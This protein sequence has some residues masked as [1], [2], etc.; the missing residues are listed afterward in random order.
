MSMVRHQ[1]ADVLW[2]GSAQGVIGALD[3]L[4]IEIEDRLDDVKNL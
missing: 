3:D 1:S 2:S 4:L